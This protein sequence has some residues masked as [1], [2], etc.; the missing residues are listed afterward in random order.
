MLGYKLIYVNN[1]RVI[2]LHKEQGTVIAAV[3]FRYNA[4]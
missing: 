2:S 4:V 1:K 3:N